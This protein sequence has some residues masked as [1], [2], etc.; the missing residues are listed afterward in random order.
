MKIHH[1]GYGSVTPQGLHGVTRQPQKTQGL[2]TS[3]SAVQ[4][5][6][7]A[8][9]PGIGATASLAAASASPAF[10]SGGVSPLQSRPL[11]VLGGALLS[12]ARQT[13]L[14]SNLSQFQ[15]QLITA[16]LEVALREMVTQLTNY[17]RGGGQ[18]PGGGSNPYEGGGAGGGTTG[19]TGISTGVSYQNMTTEQRNAA[20]GMSE[21]QRAILHLWGIQMGSAGHQDGGVL[22]NVLNNPEKFKPAEVALARELAARE[23]ALYGGI[24]GKS[25]DNEFFG[26]YQTL[27]GKDISQ[28]YGNAPIRYAQGPVNMDNRL[29]GGNGLSQFE[30]EVLQLWGHS[31]LFT[32]GKIDGSIINYALNSNNRMEVNLNPEHLKMLRDADM[33]SDGVFNGDSLENAMVDVLDRVYLGAPSATPQR[34]MNDALEEAS[35]RRLGL[36]PPPKQSAPSTPIGSIGM[37]QPGRT[38]GSCPFIGQR[39]TQT[40]SPYQAA[41]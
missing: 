35:L 20:S 12:S 15:T 29:T 3:A 41:A 24:T 7:D 9:M 19:T 14:R 2:T 32:G 16:I 40:S 23:Q 17:L 21:H 30:N 36:L 6:R 31:P 8:F 25:L 22:L 5:T 18:G 11:D 39:P 13:G 4:Q 26:L 33:A 28:R 38:G 10:Y 34:T 1:Y 37:G 27:T